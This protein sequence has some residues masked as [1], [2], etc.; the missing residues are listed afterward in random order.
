MLPYVGEPLPRKG[1][2][3]RR[4]ISSQGPGHT[5][6]QAPTLC[7]QYYIN[8]LLFIKPVGRPCGTW[9]HYAMR[10]VKDMGQQMGYRS[11]E[12]NWPKEAM[13]RP[14]GAGIVDGAKLF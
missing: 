8:T 9:M 10:D 14:I 12:W 5:D 2:R 3:F 11:L 4:D 1:T 6:R 13:N 7:E